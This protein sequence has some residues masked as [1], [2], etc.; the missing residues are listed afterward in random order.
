MKKLRYPWG[1][2]LCASIVAFLGISSH[3]QNLFEADEGSGHIY[4]FNSG[5]VQSTFASGISLPSALAFNSQGN[6]FVASIPYADV[7]EITPNG[8]KNWLRLLNVRA[9][10]RRIHERTTRGRLWKRAN[11]VDRGEPASAHAHRACPGFRS[12]DH[13][14]RPGRHRGRL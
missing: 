5:G 6:L 10:P 12:L 14:I 7:V 11:R 1:R 8:T 9:R 13:F 2:V 4:S 3:A